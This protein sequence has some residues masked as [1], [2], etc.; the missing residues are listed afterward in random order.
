M[1][2]L[3][4]AVS[5]GSGL[6]TASS[7]ALDGRS[8]NEK[9]LERAGLECAHDYEAKPLSVDDFGVHIKWRAQGILRQFPAKADKLAQNGDRS[10]RSQSP[11]RSVLFNASRS[12][13]SQG[14]LLPVCAVTIARASPVRR[15]HTFCE[16]PEA[17]NPRPLIRNE[18]SGASAPAHPASADLRILEG[19]SRAA[20]GADSKGAAAA[21]F[22]KMSGK[23][24]LMVRML[25]A[26]L[27][28]VVSFFEPVA[29]STGEPVRRVL[30]F[31]PGSL[32]DI[33][34]LIPFL[35]SLRKGFPGASTSVVC[36]CG[37]S[38]LGKGYASISHASIDALVLR[39][40]LA[41]ELIPVPIP[42]M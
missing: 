35:K 26:V 25:E 40:G 15:F 5:S 21:L 27:R 7:D 2:T 11:A 41:D 16:R 12:G 31:E 22:K 24:R 4:R 29:R 28:P 34:M 33:I 17:M 38:A 30:V 13:A 19:N 37:S 39:Q 18:S 42:Q 1:E 23:R 6:A 14:A 9:A 10:A 36:R 3:A 20:I 8:A 32:G